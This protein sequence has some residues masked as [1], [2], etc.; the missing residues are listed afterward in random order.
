MYIHV[1]VGSL[2]QLRLSWSR[3]LLSPASS[4]EKVL[5]TQSCSH[6]RVHSTEGRHLY[7]QAWQQTIKKTPPRYSGQKLMY[8]IWLK[9]MLWTMHCILV[10]QILNKNSTLFFL[11]PWI[12]LKLEINNSYK[13][14]TLATA[15]SKT[16]GIV[17]AIYDQP[18]DFFRLFEKVCAMCIF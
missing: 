10:P 12:E 3:P 1:H 4:L 7:S 8:N 11:S 2:S 5:V 18:L 14:T 9:H 16:D 15:N 6:W 17:T 13:R